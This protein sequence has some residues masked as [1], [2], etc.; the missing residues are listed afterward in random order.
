MASEEMKNKPISFWE[1]DTE[2]LIGWRPMSH[3]E[4]DL[5]WKKFAEKIEE[6]VLDKYKADD[7]QRQRLFI[8]MEACA[9]KAGSTEYESGEKNVGQ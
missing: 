6:E 8:G 2:E 5:C 1:E 3:E 7:L 4:M 9:K